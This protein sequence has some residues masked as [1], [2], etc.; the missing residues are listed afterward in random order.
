[1]PDS[2]PARHNIVS[3]LYS[4]EGMA[5]AHF[6][7][8]KEGRF[9]GEKRLKHAEQMLKRNQVQARLALEITKRL[10][11]LLVRERKAP[12]PGRCSSL[13]KAWRL[14]QQA[15]EREFPF[16]A[17]EFIER[18]PARF[19]WVGLAARELEEILY[20]LSRNALQAMATER[21]PLGGGMHKLIIR[22]Q[23]GFSTKEE[24]FALVNLADTGRGIPAKRLVHLF[25]PFY[26][27]K[28][29]VSG[30]GLGLYLVRELLRRNDGEITVSSFE[31]FGTTFTL[32][33]P[34]AERT[35]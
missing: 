6:A 8:V 32:E 27:T 28:S 5:D 2:F 19:P 23:L 10:G 25:R 30:N 35:H 11:D 7:Q 26:T 3:L 18:I 24:P 20:A 34:I 31:E 12:G 9:R 29:E 15:L 17:V 1:M 22:A 14:T 33:L 21:N 16:V 13:E 4:L